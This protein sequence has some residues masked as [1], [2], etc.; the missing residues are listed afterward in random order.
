MLR[1]RFSRWA[2]GLE[3]EEGGGVVARGAQSAHKA[4]QVVIKCAQTTLP[5]QQSGPVYFRPK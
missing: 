1:I 3:V 2:F 4:W 5:A